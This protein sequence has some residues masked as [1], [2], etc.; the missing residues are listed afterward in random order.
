MI[1]HLSSSLIVRRPLKR[2]TP[3]GARWQFQ[4]RLKGQI[5]P[6][7]QFAMRSTSQLC[8]QYKNQRS[9][10]LAAAGDGSYPNGMSKGDSTCENH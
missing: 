10:S 4:R 7:S 9:F 3:M 6:L 5:E 1:S 2:V 8:T